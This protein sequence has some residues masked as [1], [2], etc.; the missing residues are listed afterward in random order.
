LFT[1]EPFSPE[2]RNHG[3][4]G[5]LKDLR[6][7]VLEYDCRIVFKLVDEDTALLVNIG[8]HKEVY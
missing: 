3:L 5:K 6:A 2:L 8:T 4:S 7:I 1:K